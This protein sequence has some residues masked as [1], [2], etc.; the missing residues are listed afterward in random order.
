GMEKVIVQSLAG[1][2]P[3]L[4]DCYDGFAL[5]A[6]AK[7]GIAWDVTEPLTRAGVEVERV[8]WPASFPNVLLDGRV[9]G[10]PTNAAANALWFNK[11]IFEQAGIPDPQGP[12]TWEEFL[13]LAQRLTIRDE[14]GRVKQF[15]FLCDWW[16]W[17]QFV[18]QWGGHLYTEDGT[19]CIVDGPQAV[20]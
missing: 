8:V 7:S 16:N 20:A 1:V 10:F 19:R 3:D 15:G 18:L 5:S 13:S 4:F 14:S 12:R 11:A 17:P 6:Y 9:Y 2:G